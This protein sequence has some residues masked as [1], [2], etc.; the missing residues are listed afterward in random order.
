[1]EYILAV[2]NAAFSTSLQTHRSQVLQRWVVNTEQE[3]PPRHMVKQISHQFTG[4]AFISITAICWIPEL[5]LRGSLD[6]RLSCY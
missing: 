2:I 1:M 3:N 6:N 5:F 4:T